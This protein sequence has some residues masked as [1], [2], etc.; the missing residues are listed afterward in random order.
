MLSVNPYLNFNGNAG[1]A[2][3]FYKS[4]FGGEFSVVMRFKDV[5]DEDKVAG[6]GDNRLMHIALPLKSGTVLMASDTPQTSPDLVTG[7]NFCISIHTESEEE[8]D[9][10]FNALA[11]GG[12]VT[13]PLAKTFWGSYFGMLTDRFNIQWML[14]HEYGQNQ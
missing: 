2:F 4:V 7:T 11:A 3:E 9:K 12:K 5:P 14:S 10:L 8:T 1:E 6:M 13:M